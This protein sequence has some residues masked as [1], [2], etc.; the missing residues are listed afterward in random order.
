MHASTAKN[1]NEVETTGSVGGKD[2]MGCGPEVISFAPVDKRSG[3]S[4]TLRAPEAG[5][6]QVVAEPLA[7]AEA[8]VCA[9]SS[10]EFETARACRR[11]LLATWI[12]RSA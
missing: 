4:V 11:V 12:H 5:G 2:G 7:A 10:P 9:Q 6:V 1:A 8:V 3:E